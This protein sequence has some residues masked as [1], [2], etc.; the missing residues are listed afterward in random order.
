MFTQPDAVAEGAD[1]LGHV[2][3]GP[4]HFRQA[5]IVGPHADL[6]R[7]EVRRWEGIDDRP[8]EGFGQQPLALTGGLGE[9][10]HIT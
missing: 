7:G 8:W 6:R 4:A 3:A 1:H 2:L 9:G 10:F 5:P